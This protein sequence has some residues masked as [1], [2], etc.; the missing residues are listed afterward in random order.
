MNESVQFSSDG[1]LTRLDE[2]RL[3]RKRFC[4]DLASALAGWKG[5]ESLVV[6]LC[7]EWGS[8]K[9]TIKNFVIQ[10]LEK[11][12]LK[13]IVGKFN[14]WQWT[15]Q[16]KLLTGLLDE[17]ARL[18]DRPEITGQNEKLL[19][20]FKVWAAAME[21]GKG[22]IKAAR[23]IFAPFWLLAGTN[24]AGLLL[25]WGVSAQAVAT[26]SFIATMLV[27]VLSSIPGINESVIKFLEA[28]QASRQKT[29]E[30][31]RLEVAQEMQT[32]DRPII[33]FI[34]DIDR[35]NNDEVK[36]LIQLVK[37]NVH[38]P[39]L[40]YC[41]LYQKDIVAAALKTIISDDGDRYLQKIVQVQF[42]VPRPPKILLQRIF[43][44]DL[45]KILNQSGIEIVQDL[46]RWNE[47]FPAP[48]WGYFR[49]VRDI[50]RFLSAFE[51][52]FNMHLND[53]VLEVNPIDLIAVETLRMF[54]HPAFLRVG[55]SFFAA[56]IQA[57]NLFD[58]AQV[59]KDFS[60]QIQLIVND[61][62]RSAEK[63]ELL[64]STLKFLFP[65]A[66]S[67]GRSGSEQDWLLGLRICH[68][69][70]FDKYFQ[71]TLDG[72]QLSARDL[73][74]LV[75]ESG[76]RTKVVEILRD[77]LAKTN[78]SDFLEFVMAARDRIPTASLTAFLTAL[79]DIGDTFPPGLGLL[80]TDVQMQ[81]MRIIHH[82]LKVEPKQTRI[83]VLGAALAATTGV[84][85][86]D[87]AR[88]FG[89]TS[90]G[91]AARKRRVPNP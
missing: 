3:D 42:D 13:P 2:D 18:I 55:A 6:S 35:L 40:I 52:Y 46:E 70:H 27:A 88:R 81:L 32:L 62:D 30:E 33:I 59:T 51:F 83:K 5:R 20:K 63:K 34:D 41:L 68:P 44:T 76:D 48:L 87:P 73:S 21:L 37:A 39:K 82:R 8:G 67:Q 72:G 65:Q 28:R 19:L 84:G 29:I 91:K 23:P 9:T 75:A 16:D 22:L 86:A 90:S 64:E 43:T 56:G 26:L 47:L 71:T 69:N 89:G 17:L 58:E 45:E 4:A 66:Q 11:K 24:L 78:P 10:E 60:A 25:L 38:F 61:G 57:F 7:G 15:G 74:N 53:R 85:A 50:K 36:Q 12:D 79:F 31:L 80:G 49:N 54:D 14:P 1:P 77:A